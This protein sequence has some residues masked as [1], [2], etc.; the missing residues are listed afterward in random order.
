[1]FNKINKCMMLFIAI[2]KTISQNK[3]D[4]STSMNS[5]FFSY[6][7]HILTLLISVLF[8]S[9]V[10]AQPYIRTSGGLGQYGYLEKD[11]TVTNFLVG[12]GG[13]GN[14]YQYGVKSWNTNG[15]GSNSY[16]YSGIFVACNGA[17]ATTGNYS[18]G[19]IAAGNS[20]YSSV[21]VEYCGTV[22][23]HTNMTPTLACF[24]ERQYKVIDVDA[25]NT[26]LAS[27]VTQN[28]NNLVLSF[29]IDPGGVTGRTLNRLWIVNDG[30]ATEGT[31]INNAGFTLFYENITGSENFGGAESSA[32][33][34]GDYG[35]NST[36]NNEYGRDALGITIPS[37]GLRCYVVLNSMNASAYCKNVR[38]S[39]MADGISLDNNAVADNN[40]LVRMS[41]SPASGTLI[42]VNCPTIATSTISGSP[43]CAGSA[44]SVPYTITGTFVTGN[45]FTAQLSNASGSFAAPTNIGTLSSTTAGTISA[46]IPSGTANGTGYLIRV[47]ATG[48]ITGTDNGT[49]LSV[50]ATSTWIGGT[51]GNWETAS[52]WC[53]GVPTNTSNVVVPAGVNITI[54]ANASANSVVISNTGTLTFAGT[55]TLTITSGGYLQND[56]SFV[57]STGRVT[58][59]SGT[60]SGANAINFNNVSLGGTLTLS[61]VPTINGTL[62]INGSG[63][64]A[65]APIYGPNSTLNYNTGGSYNVASEWTGNSA[66]PGS[67][68][69][70]NVT[71][72]GA[73]TNVI[74]P[75]T[76]RGVGGNVSVNSGTLTLSTTSGADLYIGGD[77][78]VGSAATVIKNS[79]AI[80]FNGASGNQTITKTGSG[81]VYFDYLIINK[82][83]GDIKLNN[84][85][86]TNVQ[87][88]SS[89]NNVSLSVLQLLSGGIDLNDQ[90][91][92]LNGS[93]SNST[94]IYTAGSGAKRIY[95]STGV[96][97]FNVSA[98]VITP[99]SPNLNVSRASSSSSLTFDA[100]VTLAT[101]VGVN[102]GPSGM[103]LVN[104]IFQINT[105]GFCITNSPDYGN[106]STLIYNNGSGGFKRN[107]EW[108][109]NT[110][111]VGFPHN[112]IV[113]NSTPLTLNVDY[114][115]PNALGCSGY[116]DIKSGS[117]IDMGTMP[118]SLNSGTDLV[119]SGTLILSSVAGGDLNVGGNWTR[120]GTFT[121]NDRNVTFNGTIDGILTATDGQLFSFVYLNKSSSTAKLTLASDVRVSDEIGFTRGTLDLGTNSKFV[122]LLS[123]SSKT[124][125]VGQS[126]FANTAF[127]YG[128]GNTGQ[129]IIQR[130]VPAK[131]AWRLMSP[132]V[133][134]S[135]ASISQAWQ[136]GMAFNYATLS[137]HGA[138]TLTAGFATQ[139]TGGS[140]S[141]GFDLSVQN[142]PSIF[143][144]DAGAWVAP[145][146]TNSTSVKNK[147]GW[148][149]FVR[150]DRKNYGQIT[151]QYK[152]P[153]ITTLRP[154]GEIFIGQKRFPASGTITGKHVI[155]NPFA[156][157]FDFHSAYEATKV[158]NGGS[159]PYADQYYMWDPKLG[160]ANGRGAFVTYTWSGSN[161]TRTSAYSPISLDDRYIP[162]GAAFIVD[163]GVTGGYLLINESDKN[164]ATTTK[165][166]RPSRNVTTKLNIVEENGDTFITDGVVNLFDNSYKNEVDFDD[167]LKIANIEGENLGTK[168]N[169]NLISIEKRELTKSTD[170]IFLNW[171]KMKVRDYQL[172]ITTDSI[173]S[174]WVNVVLDDAHTK[175]QTAILEG[176]TNRYNFKIVKEDSST[177]R[178]D[179]FKIIMQ[180]DPPKL[181][182]ID[183]WENYGNISVQYK[184]TNPRNNNQIIIEKSSDG[185]QFNNIDEYT[186]HH[187]EILS[188]NVWKDENPFI[189]NNYY[190]L[191]IIGESGQIIYSKIARI[192]ISKPEIKLNANPIINGKVELLFTNMAKGN[193]QF[194]LTNN[195]GQT[196]LTKSLLHLGGNNNQIISLGVVPSKGVY[197]LSITKPDKRKENIKVIY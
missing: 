181:D 47:I 29:K 44:V 79:R 8:S 122:T 43:F 113:Q 67:G 97:N 80:V 1:M 151:N 42:N 170:T 192:Y 161:Y 157:A 53:G 41:K 101:S 94:N 180:Y 77:Y 135:N 114:P 2:K 33:L 164:N 71:I 124:A 69:P 183:A 139:I 27:T 171:S 105:N 156:S 176:D 34:Y 148:M 3:R 159:L 131:R 78:T 23:S 15:A 4:R 49:N 10:F 84:S 93:E 112:I 143:Y 197:H 20:I 127:V 73:S 59:G 88:N 144:Y 107:V 87:I 61:T 62:L 168:R 125:R 18:F 165:A 48:G 115:A 134:G 187:G 167:A 17:D 188:L 39:V 30:T 75:N 46:T 68:I 91:F 147:E 120:T 178:A 6:Y 184:I 177:F 32:T 28:T 110:P 89:T 146:N 35:G 141:N 196:T 191:G 130:Y 96:G 58:F 11:A 38:L 152:T 163:F 54:G 51:T 5:N 123:T 81:I 121:Q 85:P 82:A 74:L 179:R 155:G 133:S 36:S 119:I 169:D 189:G 98:S 100:N 12:N 45:T 111:G 7:F 117:S 195:L 174:A 193:Y 65:S 150:G 158:A 160:G 194:S 102:F 109:S 175:K 190:R 86:A 162:S 50:N 108:N 64:V 149:L 31:D 70:K 26:G 126:S 153:T 142:N 72:T 173:Q 56:G 182:L 13:Y 16:V 22:Y 19:T 24:N 128:S 57:A 63:A 186:Y 140:I 76:N 103:T 138:D 136:E 21:F 25:D 106:A 132:P 66:T 172:E 185:I 52:N 37:G 99:G 118:Y 166:Y 83:S 154:R 104:S 14:I 95:T 40:R 116:I 137:S 9:V 145:A 90:T 92:T 55:F 129:F 60:V